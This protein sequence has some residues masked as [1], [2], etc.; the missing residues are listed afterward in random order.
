M[1][2]SENKI[3]FIFDE[4]HSKVICED[5]SSAGIPGW[6]FGM[7]FDK[8]WSCK[9]K[10]P[11]GANMFAFY[12][13]A[14]SGIWV[15]Q[16]DEYNDTWF[17]PWVKKGGFLKPLDK[18]TTVLSLPGCINRYKIRNDVEYIN[19]HNA[20]WKNQGFGNLIFLTGNDETA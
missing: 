16:G 12:H 3:K 14:P 2:K 15:L 1:V 20:H 9:I 18:M 11:E 17:L 19:L 7:H 6:D 5:M 10:V 13:L 4:Q 8:K